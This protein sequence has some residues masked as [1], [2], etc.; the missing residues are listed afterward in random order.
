MADT[1]VVAPVI[2]KTEV[3]EDVKEEEKEE[4]GEVNVPIRA[5]YRQPP[6]ELLPRRHLEVRPPSES[7]GQTTHQERQKVNNTLM[8]REIRVSGILF[9]TIAVAVA[10]IGSGYLDEYII[11]NSQVRI[12]AGI[13]LYNK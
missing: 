4:E 7:A 10:V 13:G 12:I 9:A 3:I 1:E 2:E 5:V 6:E 8:A 11:S